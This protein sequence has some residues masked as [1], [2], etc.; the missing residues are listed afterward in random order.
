MKTQTEIE[1]KIQ[2][3]IAQRDQCPETSSAAMWLHQRI[4]ALLWACDDPRVMELVLTD[5][6]RLLFSSLS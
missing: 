2:E 1:A 6:A 3:L 4:V 5:E